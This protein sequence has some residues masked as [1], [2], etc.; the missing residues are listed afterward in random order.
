MKGDDDFWNLEILTQQSWIRAFDNKFPLLKAQKIY[1]K[2]LK[3]KD[4]L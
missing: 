3:I 4:N 2:A 1:Y